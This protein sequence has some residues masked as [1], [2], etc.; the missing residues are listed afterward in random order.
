MKGGFLARLNRED[1]DKRYARELAE[2]I[3]LNSKEL[4]RR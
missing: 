1:V 4:D 3:E 2:K